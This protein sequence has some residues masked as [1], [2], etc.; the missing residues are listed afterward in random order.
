MKND[1]VYKTIEFLEVSVVLF[2]KYLYNMLWYR[3][4]FFQ[5]EAESVPEHAQQL[6]VVAVPTVVL[7]R[8]R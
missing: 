4:V 7:L 8:V 2:F 1:A 3:S 5:A 6:N